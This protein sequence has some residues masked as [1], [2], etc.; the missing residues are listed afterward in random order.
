MGGLILEM[1]WRSISGDGRWVGR[2]PSIDLSLA[3]WRIVRCREVRPMGSVILA[4]AGAKERAQ[5][6]KK[7]PRERRLGYEW[8]SFS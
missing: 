4:S 7:P 5:K 3:P 1:R 2:L 8:L 6:R